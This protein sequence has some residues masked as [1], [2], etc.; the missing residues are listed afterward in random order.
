METYIPQYIDKGD[1]SSGPSQ[2]KLWMRRT[3]FGYDNETT[4]PPTKIHSVWGANESS[5]TM[6]C[7]YYL[8]DAVF[9]I[10]NLHFGGSRVIF[11]SSVKHDFEQLELATSPLLHC[12]AHEPSVI[13]AVLEILANSA[14]RTVIGRVARRSSTGDGCQ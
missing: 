10:F 7:F 13:L 4:K 1:Y 6:R 5:L 12:F 8:D 11:L 9:S 2:V 3:S 14:V